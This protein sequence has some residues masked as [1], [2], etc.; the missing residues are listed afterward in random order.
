[1]EHTLLGEIGIVAS[2]AFAAIGGGVGVGI[3]GVATIGAWKKC[4]I[5]N[6][7]APFIMLVF[8]GACLSNVIYGFIT[9]TVLA[10]STKLTDGWLLALGSG[11]GLAIG[12]AAIT[13]SMC[14]AA[15]SDAFGET[16]QGFGN[17]LMI[18][19]IAETVALFAMVFTILFA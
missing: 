14:G 19:G 13:Q 17:Y 3:G 11:A 18:V 7:P 2:F 4:F 16:G 8:A 12:I 6:K 9:M 10:D 15:A 5:Q 1:M